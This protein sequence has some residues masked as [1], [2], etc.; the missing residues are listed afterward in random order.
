MN[1]TKALALFQRRILALTG[2][3]SCDIRYGNFCLNSLDILTLRGILE[4]ERSYIRALP[5]YGR[6]RILQK[7]AYYIASALEMIGF[8][9]NKQNTVES[10]KTRK[11][12]PN[13][14][15]RYMRLAF[16][17]AIHDKIYL[18]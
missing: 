18:Y 10:I 16:A 11:R 8:A 3:N 9:L 17:L 6:S 7:R 5:N 15:Q 14:C 13:Y 1:Q 4:S 12:Q 2:V